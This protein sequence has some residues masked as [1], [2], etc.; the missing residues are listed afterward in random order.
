MTRILLAI[1]L[2]LAVSGCSK[3][4]VI[5]TDLSDP[6]T[7]QS[8]V[9]I[10]EFRDLLPEDT[11]P[12]S[13][14][15]AEDVAKFKT[16]LAEEFAARR[17]LTMA[18][19]DAGCPYE[20][21]GSLLSYTKGSGWMRFLVGFGAGDSKVVTELRMVDT[22][23][24]STVFAGNFTGQVSSWADSGDKMFKMVSRDFT[25]Q[26]EKRARALLED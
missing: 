1:A 5:T 16:Y 20:V 23:D 17:H 6:L 26:L 3:P 22:R 12:D 15:T 25:K 8:C 18:V 2:V 9:Q 4:Y 19:S 10:A 7:D 24:G 21:Q 14:P 13:R 11:D